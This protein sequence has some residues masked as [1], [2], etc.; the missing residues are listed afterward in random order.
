M[1]QRMKEMRSLIV[2]GLE[3]AAPNRD[4]S[5]IGR[6]KGMFSYLGVS[7]EQV[8]ALKKDYGIYLVDSGRINVCGVTQDNADY[9][10]ES[11]AAVL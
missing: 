2:A 10:S 3:K 6:G 8:A 1:R 11:I 5:Q 7:P 9:L 4:F